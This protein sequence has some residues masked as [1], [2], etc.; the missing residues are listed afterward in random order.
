[1]AKL[2]F[3]D[4][5]TTSVRHDRQAWEIAMIVRDTDAADSLDFEFVA[6]I[7]DVDLSNADPYSLKI[8]G[9]DNR[10]ER[11]GRI[12]TA[13]Q[14]AYWVEHVTRDAILVGVNPAFDAET[15]A[16]LL[17]D[18][19]FLPRWNYHLIDMPA[20]ALG[21]F[22]GRAFEAELPTYREDAPIDYKSYALSEA[23]GVAPPTETDRHTALGDARWVARWY[24]TITGGVAA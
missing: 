17:R 12:V 3:L 23:C 7:S 5:E 2:V 6:K 19:G 13:G 10:N 8:G 20:M 24:D 21:W 9:Y 11:K 1:M 14:A 4:T 22:H 15:L 16:T 18:N